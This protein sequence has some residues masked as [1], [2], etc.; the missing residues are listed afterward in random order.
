MKSRIIQ[1]DRFFFNSLFEMVFPILCF[2]IFWWS[3]L[4][5][6]NE[7]SIIMIA[8][9]SGLGLGTLISIAIRLIWKPDIYKLSSPILL[10]VYSFYN[11]G[12]FG[13]FMG[14]PVFHPVLGI[15]AVYYWI[16]RLIYQ[17][18]AILYKSEIDRISKFTSIVIGIVCLLSGTIALSSKSTPYDLKS[19][20]QLR[21]DIS[22]PI[23]ITFIIVGGLFLITAQYWLTKI[24]MITMLKINDTEIP[25]QN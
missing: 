12:L 10:V 15:I 3:S 8:A 1:F 25:E 17:N 5:F 20:L 23:L 24:T 11:I 21:F 14:V 22:Q 6:T 18:D 16:K 9:L 7:E 4:L 13:F 2:L 19:M